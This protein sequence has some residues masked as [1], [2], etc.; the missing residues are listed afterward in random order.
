[1]SVEQSTHTDLTQTKT[2]GERLQQLVIRVSWATQ[3]YMSRHLEQFGLTLPQWMTL[4]AL[5]HL[6]RPGCTL[7]E[8]CE[9]SHQVPATMTGI[10][11]R[12]AQRHL[13]ERQRDPRNRRALRITL[14]TQGQKLIEK[15]EQLQNQHFDDMLSKFS[16]K[17]Q[18]ILI[19]MMH[20]YLESIL[21]EIESQK[22][23]KIGKS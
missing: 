10:I 13:V 21:K 19:Q 7:N 12:L 20:Q 3:R 4:R 14:T 11:D 15:I 16:P 2:D 23:D 6:T 22:P 8:L 5:A 17:E 1:M 9:A 18:E